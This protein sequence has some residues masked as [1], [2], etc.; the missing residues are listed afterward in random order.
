MKIKFAW[1]SLLVAV[2][3][4]AAAV[5]LFF[6]FW[7]ILFH[8]NPI[9][10]NSLFDGLMGALL[11]VFITA[12]VAFIA[13]WQLS[14]IAKTTSTD[15]IH[16][17]RNDF[18]VATTR[19]LIDHLVDNR[20][21]YREILGEASQNEESSSSPDREMGYFEVDPTSIL[22]TFPDM[23][24]KKLLKKK[25]YLEVEIDDFLLGHFEDIG[26]FEEKGLIDTEMAYEE[27]SY[28]ILRTFENEEIK[29]YI[30]DADFWQK[31]FSS[32]QSPQKEEAI[33]QLYRT[34]AKE[35][36]SQSPTNPSIEDLNDLLKMPDLYKK[37]TKVRKNASFS[38]QVQSLLN[39]AQKHRKKKFSDLNGAAQRIRKTFNRLVLEEA[40]PTQVPKNGDIQGDDFDPDMYSKFTYIYYKLK[41]FEK[42]KRELRG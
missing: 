40:Y 1:S 22:P 29:K 18:F 25:Y 5:P 33:A 42:K 17:L 34:I 15:F 31:E 9:C 6:F 19:I 12:I 13:Y 20:I 4:L 16:K 7:R 41:D 24:K 14:A 27:F 21:F 3:L 37:I 35:I 30:G 28:Y 2:L 39:A 38:E 8:W 23:L 11:G 32:N 26:L 36:F 10:G